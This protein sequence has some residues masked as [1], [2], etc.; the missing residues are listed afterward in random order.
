MMSENDYA[1]VL[2]QTWSGNCPECKNNRGRGWT[3][4]ALS[5]LSVLY[6]KLDPESVLVVLLWQQRD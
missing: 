1:L 6:P 3:K 5:H 4:V 2:R